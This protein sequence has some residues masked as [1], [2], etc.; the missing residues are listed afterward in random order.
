MRIPGESR[1]PCDLPPGKL[2]H[3]VREAMNDSPWILSQTVHQPAGASERSTSLMII[4]GNPVIEVDTSLPGTRVVRVL[5][6]PAE[7]RGLPKT[8]VVYNGTELVSKALD[9]WAYRNHIRLH[10]IEPG[11]LV[12]SAI[13]ESFNGR[14]RDKCLNEHCFTNH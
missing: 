10:F 9:E 4:V 14:F 11:K 5:E 13:V 2:S 6:R 3:D 12:Q 1:V 8:I 7:T